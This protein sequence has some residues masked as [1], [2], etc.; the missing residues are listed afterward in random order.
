MFLKMLKQIVLKTRYVRQQAITRT[1]S[2]NKYKLQKILGQSEIVT[3]CYA[4]ISQ[5][6]I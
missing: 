6:K 3:K 4:N 5:I 2:K 1:A